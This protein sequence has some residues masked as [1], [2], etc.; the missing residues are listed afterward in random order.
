ME[1]ETLEQRFIRVRKIFADEMRKIYNCDIAEDDLTNSQ[2]A[3][4]SLMIDIACKEILNVTNNEIQKLRN[5]REYQFDRVDKHYE[6]INRDLVEKVEKLNKEVK[7]GTEDYAQ[8]V[9]KNKQDINNFESDVL[10]QIVSCNSLILFFIGSLIFCSGYYLGG[11]KLLNIIEYASSV[12]FGV[13]SFYI[14]LSGWKEKSPSSI[15]FGALSLFAAGLSPYIVEILAK[16][17]K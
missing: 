11:G 12:I 6:E 7:T 10:K 2:L 5:Q 9:K 8:L 17:P 4:H 3:C 15:F 16:Y 13:I 1:N 14:F